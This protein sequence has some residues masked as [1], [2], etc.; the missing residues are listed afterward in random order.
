[1]SSI[2]AKIDNF[3]RTNHFV[4]KGSLCVALVV[5]QHARQLGLPLDSLK[6][7]TKGGGQVR[8]LGRLA[9]QKILSRHGISRLLASEGGRTSRGSLKRMRLYVDFLND[10]NASMEFEIDQIELYWIGRVRE[11]FAS[12]PFVLNLDK[13]LSVQSVVS[14]LIEQANRRQQKMMGTNCLG[15]VIQH[16]VGAKLELVLGH[17]EIQKTAMIRGFHHNTSTA[18]SQT[19]RAGDF[20][21]GRTSIHVTAAPSEALIGRCQENLN[22]GMNPIIV[23]I[24]DK[25]GLAE[26]LAANFGV[27]M[28]VDILTIEQFIAIYIY[29]AGKFRA[30]NRGIAIQGLIDRYNTIINQVETDPSL[31]IVLRT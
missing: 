11:F 22:A 4:G 10:L 31:K 8:G 23:T 28:R 14:D 19:G 26:G 18:D 13:S 30:S 20:V 6:L 9:V 27:Q 3:A 5:T 2:G 16:L 7:V 29:E 15:A 25:F 17:S 1:M 21:I 24:G 12:R